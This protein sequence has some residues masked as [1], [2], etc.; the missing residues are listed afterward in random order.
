MKIILA[1]YV[2]ELTPFVDTCCSIISE[3]IHRNQNAQAVRKVHEDAI[4][5]NKIEIHCSYKPCIQ[6]SANPRT[7]RHSAELLVLSIA[8]PIDLNKLLAGSQGT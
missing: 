4:S 6:N 1:G 7:F 8:M 5:P 2:N 3:Y